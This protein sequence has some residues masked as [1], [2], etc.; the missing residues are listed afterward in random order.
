MLSMARP[1]RYCPT[2]GDEDVDEIEEVESPPNAK[3]PN[4]KSTTKR[5]TETDLFDD[6][7]D[8]DED[9]AAPDD[10]SILAR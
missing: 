8:E 6:M 4:E 5:P 9:N 10:L 3:I 7:N 1:V 2:N